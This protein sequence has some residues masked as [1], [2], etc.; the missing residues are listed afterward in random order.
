VPV[1]SLIMTVRDGER[2]LAQAIESVRAQTFADW[3][4][5]VWDDGSTD[6]T[7]A[8]IRALAAQEPR[9]RAFTGE[10]LGRRRA[11]VEAHRRA[12]GDLVGWIDADD[13]L[14]PEA[15]ARTH[16][17][18]T[19]SG[20]DLVYTDHVIA[21][22][23]GEQR[24]L[25]RRTRIPYTPRGLLTD[26][27]TFHFRLFTRAVFERAGGIDPDREIAIDYDLCLRIS[28]VGRIRHLAEPLYFYREH[29]QQMST[30]K[31]RAQIA[32]SAAAIRAAL[33]RRGLSA[34]ALDV[35]LEH[36]RFR[37]V[38]AMQPAALGPAAWLRLAVATAVP[39]LRRAHAPGGAGV[40]GLWPVLRPSVYRSQLY[41]AVEARGV[42]VL[43]IRGGLA[44]LIR[45]VWTGRAGTTLHIL[46]LGPV[47]DDGDAGTVIGRS[48][49][50]VATLDHALARGMRLV[51]T[52]R[53]PLSAHPRHAVHEAW[54]R[55][56]LAERCHAIVTHWPTDRDRLRALGGGDRVM[57]VPHPSVGDGYPDVSRDHAREALGVDRD[58][59]AVLQ[60]GGRRSSASAL[61]IEDDV[62][63]HAPRDVALRIAA[64]DVL[65][66][67]QLHSGA[68]ALAMS[69]AKPIVA[70]ALPGVAEVVGP[71]AFLYPPSGGP[72][73]FDDA[74]ARA[75]AARA[76]WARIG[77][78]H[79]ARVRDRGWDA[80]LAALVG[81]R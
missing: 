57:Y 10:P 35:D 81:R 68:L 64:A 32:A 40:V 24:G 16:A 9:I 4:L 31:R 76:E 60:L 42:Q 62:D 79:L 44:R 13:W 37:L 54:C 48:R 70:P 71:E 28:E 55:R 74:V 45:A 72:R 77:E 19:S 17:A 66:V 52:S 53:G 39:R 49:L 67:P 41:A 21:S 58:A 14:A 27:M 46:G 5:V 50:F 65:A 7:P 25:G 78:G 23:D 75:Y 30:A 63:R 56:A 61:V 8:I 1:I 6:G 18:R 12:R 73:A 38:P 69:V 80:P 29:R 34:H 33:V 3:E 2:Y 59:P 36:G 22:A 43:P 47:L 20:A 51:W 11:L 26:F 15:L